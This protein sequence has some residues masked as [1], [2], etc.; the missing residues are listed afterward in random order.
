[1]VRRKARRT[2][3]FLPY[4]TPRT[5]A[6]WQL[7]RKSPPW[8]GGWHSDGGRPRRRWPATAV[9]RDGGGPR[10]RWPATA[11]AEPDGVGGRVEATTHPRA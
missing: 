10:Q 7:L 3:H 11:V 2:L 6:V 1:M 8:R 9:A 5:P 4:I